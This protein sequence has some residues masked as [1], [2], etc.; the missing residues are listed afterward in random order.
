MDQFYKNIKTQI[1]A[2][3]DSKT[4]LIEEKEEV[5][6]SYPAKRLVYHRTE[7]GWKNFVYTIL[8]FEANGS[9]YRITTGANEEILKEAQVEL[10]GIVDSFQFIK[11]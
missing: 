11:K 2:N 1:L 4:Y 5:F 10:Q 8:F 9:F 6:Q 3:T 7:E